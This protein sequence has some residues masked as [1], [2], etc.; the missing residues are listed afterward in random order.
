[1]NCRTSL[2]LIGLRYGAPEA[3]IAQA[4]FM[5]PAQATPG[6]SSTSAI[7]IAAPGGIPSPRS[8]P[9]SQV[10]QSEHAHDRMLAITGGLPEDAGALRTESSTHLAGNPL[11]P[12]AA[13]GE[14]A[15]D[16]EKRRENLQSSTRRFRVVRKINDL[17]AWRGN[18][19]V[20]N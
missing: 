7:S 1:M 13:I 15:A 18:C 12:E 9:C 6:K 20:G 14:P 4:T 16:R 17:T 11:E 10:G 8:F 2:H 5:N 3:S 19:L